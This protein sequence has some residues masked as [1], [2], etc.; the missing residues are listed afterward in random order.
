[1]EKQNL[2]LGFKE[3]EDN[4][5]FEN[6]IFL[7]QDKKLIENLSRPNIKNQDSSLVIKSLN[8]THIADVIQIKVN[9]ADTGHFL[10]SFKKET[11]T[12]ELRNKT[13]ERERNDFRYSCRDRG[14]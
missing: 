4:F 9:I 2:V 6:K 11:L 14:D 12:E 1:M 13:A 3:Q 8:D 7:V 5:T 10:V